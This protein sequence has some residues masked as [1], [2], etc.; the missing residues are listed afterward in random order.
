MRWIYFTC[1]SGKEQEETV[2]E[3]RVRKF[4]FQ[5]GSCATFGLFSNL[6]TS[7][8]QSDSVRPSLPALSPR[9]PTFPFFLRFHQPCTRA[10][11]DD[12]RRGAAVLKIYCVGAKMKRSADGFCWKNKMGRDGRRVCSRRLSAATSRLSR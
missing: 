6:L 7:V 12:E 4:R 5:W 10:A 2:S 1:Q 11:H 9:F 3:M 8:N